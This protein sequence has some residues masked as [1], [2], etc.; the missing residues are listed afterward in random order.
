[1]IHGETEFGRSFGH[2]DV[3]GENDVELWTGALFYTD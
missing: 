1:M 3:V 2:V